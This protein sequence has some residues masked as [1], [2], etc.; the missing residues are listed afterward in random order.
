M[1]ANA[2]TIRGVT[3]IGVVFD[4]SAYLPSNEDS[5]SSDVSLLQAVRPTVSTTGAPLIL[6][7]SPATMVGIVYTIWKRHFGPSG[8]ADCLVIQTDT[9]STNPRFKQNVI[10][11]ALE[12]DGGAE[13]SGQFQEPMSAY[14]S[15]AHV[16]ACVERG[17]T[18]RSGLPGVNFQCRIDMAGGSGADS[19]GGLICHRSRDNGRDLVICD[20]LYEVRPPFDPLDVIAAFAGILKKWNIAQTA[21]PHAQSHR[22]AEMWA[23]FS[24]GI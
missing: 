11:R 17:V 5:A 4:E 14:L 23:K 8:S 15:R 22:R 1:A 3:A 16:E 24:P 19:F 9:R 7:S 10:D 21:R 13:Y 18:E 2:K 12:E 6:M 20:V